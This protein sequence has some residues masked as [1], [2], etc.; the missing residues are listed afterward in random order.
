MTDIV[1][2]LTDT[3]ANEVHQSESIEQLNTDLSSD[4]FKENEL[5]LQVCFRRGTTYTHVWGNF[6]LVMVSVILGL[7]DVYMSPNGLSKSSGRTTR[8]VKDCFCNI[9][10]VKAN[11]QA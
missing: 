1:I 2:A 9:R 8:S 4:I 11:L 7:F 3:E 6:D 10:I 5:E